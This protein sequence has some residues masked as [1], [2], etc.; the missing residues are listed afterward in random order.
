MKHA[1]IVLF[2]ILTAPSLCSSAESMMWQDF[3]DHFR[4]PLPATRIS[5]IKENQASAYALHLL[6]PENVEHLSAVAS[7]HFQLL[8]FNEAANYYLRLLRIERTY[9]GA[10]DWFAECLY[11]AGSIEAARELLEKID[12]AGKASSISLVVLAE[13]Y[14]RKHDLTSAIERLERVLK[15]TEALADNPS[16]S[17]LRKYVEHN[18]NVMRSEL[19]K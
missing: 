15:K 10:S 8:E 14:Y 6:D 13:I 5:S 2:F 18:L 7:F 3:A 9:P 12:R 1:R 11:H 16:Y 19:K 17:M 4:Q